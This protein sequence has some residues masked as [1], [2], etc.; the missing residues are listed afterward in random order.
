M[1]RCS[2]VMSARVALHRPIVDVPGI[3]L[4][5]HDPFSCFAGKKNSPIH[6]AK[7][8]RDHGYLCAGTQPAAISV[9]RP[10]ALSAEKIDRQRPKRWPRFGSRRQAGRGR[11]PFAG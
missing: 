4:I 3:A 7:L 9:P 11:Q 1:P 6:R 10:S 8:E 5:D 2:G